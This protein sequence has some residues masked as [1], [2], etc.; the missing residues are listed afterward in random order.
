MT[1]RDPYDV[2]H[3]LLIEGPDQYSLT[4]Q[5]ITILKLDRDRVSQVI[6]ERAFRAI[7]EIDG[8]FTRLMQ[9]PEKS[10]PSRRI[11]RDPSMDNLAFSL[12]SSADSLSRA[13]S[14]SEL[15]SVDSGSLGS[16]QMS[17]LAS[18]SSPAL[19]SPAN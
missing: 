1:S 18:E 8:N 4:K 9:T 19:N 14:S 16:R 2:L 13:S 5:F 6:G 11:E 17:W 15:N 3:F 12:F 7:S 10:G